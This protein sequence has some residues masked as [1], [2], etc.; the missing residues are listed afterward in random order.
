MTVV[1][2]GLFVGPLVVGMEPDAKALA[3]FQKL[4]FHAALPCPA[5]IKGKD[6]RPTST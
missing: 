4:I 1:W 3:V 2:L 5:L 6:L